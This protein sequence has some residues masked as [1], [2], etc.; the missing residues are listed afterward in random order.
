[1]DITCVCVLGGCKESGEVHYLE[2][3]T[4]FTGQRIR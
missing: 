4:K 3:L 2:V 1:M